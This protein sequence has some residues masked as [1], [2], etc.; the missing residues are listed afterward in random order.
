MFNFDPWHHGPGVIWAIGWS[1]V[2]L[3]VLVFLPTWLI[4]GFGLAMIA[5][6]N[7]LDGFTAS[8]LHLP[9]WLWVV[10]HSPGEAPIVGRL[11]IGTGYVLIPWMGVMAAGYGFGALLLDP[12]R[13]RQRCLLLGTALTLAFVLLRGLHGYG[14]PRQRVEYADW[15]RTGL[16]FLNC[17][18]Y[19]PS[20]HYLLMTLGPSIFAIGLFD[21]PL[22]P[23]ARPIL[24]FGRVPLFYYLLHIPL[25]HGGAVLLDYLRFGWSPQATDGPWAVKPGEI[26]DTYG[27]SLPVVYVLWLVLLVLLYP[28]CAWFAELKRRRPGGW[29][30]YF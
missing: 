22:S 27:V 18:K 11:T 28:A 2:V 4:S 1:M 9:P 12:Q 17:T 30:S 3:S 15:V 16:S 10:L 7:M 5:T 21:R 13:R 25:I 20:L 19:P 14:D 23:L 6:H 29:L 8:D 26:P 24:V